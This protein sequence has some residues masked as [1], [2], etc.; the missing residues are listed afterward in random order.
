VKRASVDVPRKTA[1]APPN[2]AEVAANPCRFA[3][4]ERCLEQ[5]QS[6]D[7]HACNATG[8]LFE[9][10]RGTA[11]DGM[12]ASGFYARACDASYAPG[13]TNLAWLYS[14]GRG[15]P[16]D[17]DQAMLLFTRAFDASKLACRRG[18]GRGCL[19]AGEFMLE[20]KVTPKDEDGALAM[21]EAACSQ[22]EPRGCE[23]VET[24]R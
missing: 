21:F 17:A 12:I 3:N 5:C 9:Y 16:R 7:S 22:G 10:G 11:A 4:V 6:G 13:C 14:L 8:V 18:D 15:V 1:E 23:Y 19:M 24:L 20:G 2:P